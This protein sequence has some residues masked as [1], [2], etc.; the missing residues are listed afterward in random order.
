M[1]PAGTRPLQL[2]FM[3][4]AF[5]HSDV[6]NGTV[7]G[8]NVKK[9]PN[10]PSYFVYFRSSAG[11]RVER[12]TNQTAIAKAIEAAKAIIRKEYGK[13]LASSNKATTH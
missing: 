11:K 10:E 12:D 6:F 8:F 1:I 2:Q 7:V 5:P 13:V 9:R 3:P 4:R